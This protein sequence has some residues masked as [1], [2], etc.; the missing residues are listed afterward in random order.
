MRA[1]QERQGRLVVD[2]TDE[3]RRSVRTAL[4]AQAASDQ[5]IA[6]R[7]RALR[8]LADDAMQF[9]QHRNA[10]HSTH[11]MADHYY[12]SAELMWSETKTVLVDS[13]SDALPTPIRELALKAIGAL[14]FHR[15][16]SI[17][18]WGDPHVKGALLAGAAVGEPESVRFECHR[19]L[20]LLAC[21]SANSV[22][23][24]AAARGAIV[25]AVAPGEYASADAAAAAGVSERVRN[26]ALDTFKN[27]LNNAR[28]ST[29][30][31]AALARLLWDHDGARG[32][33]LSCVGG[34]SD[35]LRLQASA[36][37]GVAHPRGA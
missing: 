34:E 23:S 37:C 15:L 24:D 18:M 35:R 12:V 21:E 13:A 17:A 1:I 29:G 27:A 30:A 16:N 14:V 19:T 8:A 9:D 22:F 3:P 25:E 32:A 6:T 20:S 4:I 7:E 5:P 10:D 31:A 33:L 36:R 28:G 2:D 11:D 26:E